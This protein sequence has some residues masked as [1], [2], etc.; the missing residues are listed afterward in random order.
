[1]K[2]LLVDGFYYVY[3]S[4]FAI[5][6]LSNSRGEPTNAVYGFIKVLRKMLRDLEPDL[7]AVVWDEGLPT[8]RTELQPEYK[9]HRA[10]MPELMKPQIGVIRRIVP[11]LGVKNTALADTEADDLMA[12]YACAVVRA[13]GE[14]VVA[15]NDKDLFQLVEDRVSIYS[16][17]KTD[18]ATPKDPFALL[19]ADYVRS[20]WGVPPALVA[21]WLA[22]VGDTA[23]NIPG[24]PGMGPK[25]AAALLSEYGSLKE[26][27]ANP[28][29]IRNASIQQKIIGAQQAILHNQEM[30]RLDVDLPLP[31]PVEK[32]V[33]RPDYPALIAELEACEF[34]TLTAEVRAEA[35]RVVPQT[36]GELF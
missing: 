23:D 10:E 18:L 7:A 1:M 13:G 14:A 33:I 12:S 20:K 8:R 22:L 25:R 15:T 24:V 32:L 2:L 3:R 34:K 11:L 29:V 27:L 30:V 35:G 21:D 5:R 16:T 36:Q 6:E 9:Q 31:V 4:F 26:V 28:G 19:G 17:N